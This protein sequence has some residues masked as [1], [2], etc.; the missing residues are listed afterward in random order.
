M[1]FSTDC[2]DV[3]L[4][5]GTLLIYKFS[6][7]TIIEISILLQETFLR[8]VGDRLFTLGFLGASNENTYITLG[9]SRKTGSKNPFLDHIQPF[10]N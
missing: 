8:R 7:G 5:K 2:S 10:S 9:A 4:P 1:K 6:K 3:K